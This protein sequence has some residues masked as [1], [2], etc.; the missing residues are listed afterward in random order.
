M[1]P[2]EIMHDEKGKN[3]DEFFCRHITY[4]NNLCRQCINAI[5]IFE[6]VASIQE[7]V[8]QDG[9]LGNFFSISW[10]S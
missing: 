9:D 7:K 5:I 8:E 3:D 10:V 2:I 6:N 1:Q 4:Q